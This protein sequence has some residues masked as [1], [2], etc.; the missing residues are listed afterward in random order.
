M[1]TRTAFPFLTLSP[2]SFNM[3]PWIVGEIGEETD[4]LGDHVKAWDYSEQLVLSRRLELNW[5]QVALDLG[6]GDEFEIQL[7]V[8]V[9]TGQG[10]L[11]RQQVLR[12]V[13]ALDQSQSLTDVH[14]ELPGIS[15]STQIILDTEI[16]LLRASSHLSTLSP[17]IPGSRLW[18][19]RLQSR[20]EGGSSRFP[21]EVVSFDT[22]FSGQ[23]GIG[24]LWFVHWQPDEL[25]R[26]FRGAVRL[27]LNADNQ[28]FVDK[29]QAQDGIVLRM[30]L[31]DVVSQLCENYLVNVP[32][33]SDPDS[34]ESGTVGRQ[35][36]HWLRTAFGNVSV[37]HL[38]SML[39]LRPGDFRA[40]IQAAT[41]LRGM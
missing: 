13:R 32:D 38:R 18:S 1:A 9:G 27:Y 36:H 6:F 5:T 19:D 29:V 8:T 15:L 24:A 35:I 34:H 16:L 11:P 37:A 31:A 14:F 26:D 33:D 40:A 12:H 17:T 28:D 7:S 20:L 25:D 21:M 4:T 10:T 30:I 41:E 23:A 39:E 3:S 2:D 22:L